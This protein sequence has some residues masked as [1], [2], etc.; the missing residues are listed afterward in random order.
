MLTSEN[1]ASGCGRKQVTSTPHS[2]ALINKPNFYN[3]ALNFHPRFL[4]SRTTLTETKQSGRKWGQILGRSDIIQKAKGSLVLRSG[5]L[6][7]VTDEVA[8]F[9]FL[10]EHLL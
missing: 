6:A 1:E 2:L 10:R 3:G 9:S 7:D 4:C 5:M 8:T